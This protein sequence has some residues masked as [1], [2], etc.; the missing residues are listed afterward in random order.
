VACLRVLPHPL[1]PEPD[2]SPLAGVRPL[3]AVVAGGEGFRGFDQG[4]E[5]ELDGPNQGG[6]R[7]A[8]RMYSL[9]SH[10]YIHALRFRT[11]VLGVQASRRL[12]AVAL[13]AQVSAALFVE[14]AFLGVI[15]RECECTLEK[16]MQQPSIV[17]WGG[18]AAQCAWTVSF[19]LLP[20]PPLEVL[21]S[22]IRLVS[23]VH[24]MA[25]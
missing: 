23:L 16:L 10:A 24:Q 6:V 8:V 14:P 12:V 17:H 11:P 5:L 4:E 20:V 18:A 1:S 3:L 15:G 22:K 25:E 2:D 21:K 9:Q 7:S 19:G 13:S